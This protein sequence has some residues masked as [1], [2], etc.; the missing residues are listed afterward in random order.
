[1]PQYDDVIEYG[2]I[3]AVVLVYSINSQRSFQFV[4]DQLQDMRSAHDETPVVVAAN[5][6]DLVRTRQVSEDG[7][8]LFS[9]HQS[10]VSGV[11]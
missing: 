6:T 5:K 2:P 1:M 9:L 4:S 8:S 3:G 11:V 10:A 7:Q